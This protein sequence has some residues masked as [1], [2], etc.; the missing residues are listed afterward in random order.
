M[1]NAEKCYYCGKKASTREHVPP[2]C[3]F[4]ESKDIPGKDFRKNLITVPSC[5]RHNTDKSKDDEYLQFTMLMNVKSNN[6]AR[7]QALTKLMRATKRSPRKYKGFIKN[8]RRVFVHEP[9]GLSP[10]G[11]IGYTADLGRFN[12]IM[13]QI[14]AGIYLH[15]FGV[16]FTGKYDIIINGMFMSPDKPARLHRF[17]ADAEEQLKAAIGAAWFEGENQEVFRY[18]V[19]IEKSV[20]VRLDFYEHHTVII[21]LDHAGGVP[22]GDGRARKLPDTA[23]DARGL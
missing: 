12:R 15:R 9:G 21:K 4:P 5:F 11:S 14:V 16:R 22:T 23:R 13:R 7:E 8:P 6:L 20:F 3:L 10:E 19:F 2:K 18:Q 17:W 1:G